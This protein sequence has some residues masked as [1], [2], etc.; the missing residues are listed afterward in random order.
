MYVRHTVTE[1]AINTRVCAAAAGEE[2]GHKKLSSGSVAL[3]VN[4][5]KPTLAPVTASLI[6]L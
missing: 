4:V 2:F 5:L 3:E 1:R 6:Q